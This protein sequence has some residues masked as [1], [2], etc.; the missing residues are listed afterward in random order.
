MTNAYVNFY[1][2]VKS[3]ISDDKVREIIKIMLEND[4]KQ[5]ISEY[6]SREDSSSYDEEKKKQA[7]LVSVHYHSDV[8]HA[9]KT[10][11]PSNKLATAPTLEHTFFIN[12]LKKDVYSFVLAYINYCNS[13]DIPFNIRVY[14][15]EKASNIQ[16]YAYDHNLIST[17]EA[18]E[19]VMKQNSEFLK[20]AGKTPLLVGEIN[21]YLGY[22]NEVCDK[23]GNNSIAGSLEKM[24][25]SSFL[26]AFKSLYNF[27][28]RTP[29]IYNGTQ[30]SWGKFL[31]SD[32][33]NKIY[34]NF[35][36]F[37]D[38]IAFIQ[39]TFCVTAD[40]FRDPNYIKV[41]NDIIESGLE[42]LI[43]EGKNLRIRDNSYPIL[44][45]SQLRE[46]LISDYKTNPNNP[47]RK[48]K[49]DIMNIPFEK[50]IERK[51]ESAGLDLEK[52]CFKLGIQEKFEK[53]D[54]LE[55]KNVPAKVITNANDKY[56]Y[57]A[58]WL[59]NNKNKLINYRGK[60]I[61]LHD[62]FISLVASYFSQTKP[63]NYR[64]LYMQFTN[65]FSV[66][67]DDMRN[68]GNSEMQQFLNDEDIEFITEN[69][70]LVTAASYKNSAFEK[71]VEETFTLK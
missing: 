53:L 45:I 30:I 31:A 36:K 19:E 54:E 17:K 49:L 24:L 14:E 68:Y 71:R 44:K 25:E 1:K 33:A 42:D 20:G 46:L 62:F 65:V 3:P 35:S 70:D 15:N 23:K 29:F 43:M 21:P 6:G 27:Y 39:Q 48:C 9:F 16:I 67:L 38:N 11:S 13:K 59:N 63:E 32:I 4:P 5:K 12:L 61:S 7:E 51:A 2:K 66:L 69:M 28:K 10:N 57:Y 8:W 58:M 60:N 47:L 64:E 50:S 22:V 37:E 56:I 40:T 18:I 55:E 41:L 52:P 26:E 34:A